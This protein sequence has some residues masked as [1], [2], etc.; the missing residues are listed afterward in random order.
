MISSPCKDCPKVNSPKNNCLEDCPLIQ[1][2]QSIAREKAQVLQTTGDFSD[3]IRLSVHTH[4]ARS[5]AVM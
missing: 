1:G 5:H 3:D 2:V 4:A